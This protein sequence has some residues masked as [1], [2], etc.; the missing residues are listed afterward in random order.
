MTDIL[1]IQGTI[2][3]QFENPVDL[4]NGDFEFS[5]MECIQELLADSKMITLIS[6]TGTT[7]QFYLTKDF[8]YGEIFLVFFLT[9][10]TLFFIFSFILKFVNKEKVSFRG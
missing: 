10:F 7:S 6:D 9:I 8:S 5:K 1:D 3:C 4:G 2:Q